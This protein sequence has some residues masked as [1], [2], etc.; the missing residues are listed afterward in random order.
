MRVN[1]LIKTSNGA[2]SNVVLEKGTT[3]PI[4]IDD[5]MDNHAEQ[6][7][8]VKNWCDEA[9]VQ[10]AP[11]TVSGI[12]EQVLRGGKLR[13]DTTMGLAAVADICSGLCKM[14]ANVALFSACSDRRVLV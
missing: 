9:Q 3:D 5:L 8:V 6:T 11:C 1:Y 7:G 14:P 4:V 10:L 13:N 12:L 2:P